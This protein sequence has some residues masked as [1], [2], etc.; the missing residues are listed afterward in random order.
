MVRQTILVADGADEAL[1]ATRDADLFV[2]LELREADH[3]VGLEHFAVDHVAVTSTLVEGLDAARVVVRDAEDG[4]AALRH[5]RQQA[6]G[7]EVELDGVA[8]AALI[9]TPDATQ[10]IARHDVETQV[11]RPHGDAPLAVEGL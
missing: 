7:A 8:V 3:H 5:G 6:P 9:D 10:W 1:E 4:L 11:A 2:R